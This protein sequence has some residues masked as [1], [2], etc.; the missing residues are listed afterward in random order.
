[1]SISS[2]TYTV[3][4]GQ[5]YATLWDAYNDIYQ[6]GG[7]REL[8]G[9]LTFQI[10]GDV[11]ETTFGGWSGISLRLN[12]FAF[13]IEGAVAN[14]GD[15]NSGSSIDN[16]GSNLLQSGGVTNHGSLVLRNLR[17]K[18]TLGTF[19]TGFIDYSQSYV[20][21]YVYNNIFMNSFGVYGA[22]YWVTAGMAMH[23]Y[24]NKIY[25][26]LGI[27]DFGTVD[28][29]AVVENNSVYNSDAAAHGILIQG[30][31]V[32]QLKNNVSCC[33]I[34]SA[35]RFC[36]YI[37]NLTGTV[38]GWNN[39]SNDDSASTAAWSSTTSPQINIVPA[40][41][42]K[43]VTLTDSTYLFL[44]DNHR[45]VLSRNGTASVST[46][47]ADNAIPDAKGYYPIGCHVSLGGKKNQIMSLIW[48]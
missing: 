43:S 30:V 38:D 31:T 29:I 34:P 19:A 1:M 33:R 25:G 12:G 7:W 44:K 47:I 45:G 3:G 40:N 6:T 11:I 18:G 20:N 41:E 10:V 15:P 23:V 27:S 42:F 13:T 35:S 22:S 46:D 5:T 2:G 28:S 26:T 17:I 4:A 8:G 9:D 21:L 32:V 37:F 36:Y 14:N 48:T 39:A 16:W 24:C